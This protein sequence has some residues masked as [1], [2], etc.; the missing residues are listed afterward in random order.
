MPMS[1]L[2]SLFKNKFFFLF[3]AAL[4]HS[5]V[6]A[7]PVWHCSRSDVQIADASDNFTLA[8]LTFEREVIRLSLKDLYAVYQGT[9]VK[10]NGGLPLSA[11]IARHDSSLTAAALNSI[12]AKPAVVK[13]LASSNQVQTS[14]LHIVQDEASM[15][16]CIVKHHPAIGYL[17][18]ATHTEALGPCF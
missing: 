7:D 17:S 2:L 15:L 13:A 11:C 18:Q 14:H 1:R 16:A 4:M 12:G 5:P 9:P 10:L 6:W 8:A 3:S